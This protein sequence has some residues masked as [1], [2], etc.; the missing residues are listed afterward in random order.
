[1]SQNFG[2]SRRAF[3]FVLY[4]TQNQTWDS[5]MDSCIYQAAC[6]PLFWQ[7]PL[8]S[9]G[10]LLHTHFHFLCFGKSS[11]HAIFRDE[12]IPLICCGE[13]LINCSHWFFCCLVLMAL[14][15]C[16]SPW[17]TCFQQRGP[18]NVVRISLP[19]LDYKITTSPLLGDPLPC[20]LWWSK[21]LCW[22]P[23]QGKLLANGQT[24]QMELDPANNHVGDPGSGFSSTETSAEP[25]A[26]ANI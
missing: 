8:S 20:W 15:N 1:M 25:L 21:L 14:S 5:V 23:W 26:L 22:G 13:W 18:V 10:P 6:I 2:G 3:C 24:A 16:P 4:T 9:L 12:H 11:L 19:R 17:V 7:W